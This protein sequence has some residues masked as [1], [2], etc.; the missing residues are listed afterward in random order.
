MNRYDFVLHPSTLC[1]SP[2]RWHFSDETIEVPRFEPISQESIQRWTELLDL[3]GG[4]QEKFENREMYSIVFS[5]GIMSSRLLLGLGPA[6]RRE[7]FWALDV[8]ALGTLRPKL[9]SALVE[10]ADLS[11]FVFMSPTTG[12]VAH[13][14]GITTA[15][16][17]ALSD[18][19]TPLGNIDDL[20]TWLERSPGMRRVY[21][22]GFFGKLGI[23]VEVARWVVRPQNSKELTIQ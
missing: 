14:S 7:D 19:V 17:Q 21:Y 8:V 23:A 13:L 9:L 12:A 6:L 2:D 1:D 5:T 4:V 20:R 11:G 10:F 15:T 3:Y 16:A 22:K 18:D